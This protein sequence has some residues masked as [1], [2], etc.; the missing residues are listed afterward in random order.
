M[1]LPCKLLVNCVATSTTIAILLNAFVA[2]HTDVITVQLHIYI[3]SWGDGRST[4]TMCRFFHRGDQSTMTKLR[5]SM[6]AVD[7]SWLCPESLGQSSHSTM[8]TPRWL[9]NRDQATTHLEGVLSW[10][11]QRRACEGGHW[12]SSR[13]RGRGGPRCTGRRRWC[14]CEEPTCSDDT[15]DLTVPSP[16]PEDRPTHNICNHTTIT[17]DE[18]STH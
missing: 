4:V 2:F 11:R 14:D 7:Q 13:E 3:S 9:V 1:F 6:E 5:V 10:R 15:L 17:R 12:G 18:Q 8:T 16:S